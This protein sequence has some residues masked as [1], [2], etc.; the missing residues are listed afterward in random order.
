MPGLLGLTKS[1]SR[2][3]RIVGPAVLDVARHFIYRW[4]F[5][6]TQRFNWVIRRHHFTPAILPMVNAFERCQSAYLDR[7]SSVSGRSDDSDLDLDGVTVVL[8]DH[9]ERCPESSRRG[10]EPPPCDL[11]RVETLDHISSKA[12]VSENVQETKLENLYSPEYGNSSCCQVQFVRSGTFW[13]VGVST[14]R[15]IQ[16]AYLQLIDNAKSHI[17]I[18][19]RCKDVSSG[20]RLT[21]A[22]FD[23]SSCFGDKQN[24]FFVS[25]FC[26][27]GLV[28]NRVVQALYKRILRAHATG[29]K[30]KVM[31]VM[32]LLPAFEGSTQASDMGSANLRAVMFWQVSR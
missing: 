13:S 22:Y 8:D 30:F 9:G 19:V 10:A 21:P 25:G 27:D 14:E 1:W 5:V 26:G 7:Q 31:V 28:E 4:N 23:V 11:D 29:A 18:E 16:T 32:P 2:V 6:R 12:L 17:Y 3:V 24:Q 15:S 20:G